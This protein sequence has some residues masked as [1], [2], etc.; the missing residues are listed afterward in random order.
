MEDTHSVQC[1]GDE[2][3]DRG[4]RNQ[5]QPEARDTGT[6]AYQAGAGS[7]LPPPPSDS[8]GH[9]EQRGQRHSGG[10]AAKRVGAPPS[11]LPAREARAHVKQALGRSAASKQ[12]ASNEAS[13]Q[14]VKMHELRQL[15]A[16][17]SVRA[18]ELLVRLG[19]RK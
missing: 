4:E 8:R 3:V 11:E 6:A 15:A 18:A 10:A 13:K 7:D 2:P 17:G 12:A 1:A 14:Q 16:A 19:K 9:H 5:D